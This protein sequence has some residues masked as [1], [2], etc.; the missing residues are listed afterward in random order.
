MYETQRFD[1]I[2][3]RM[4]DRVPSTMAKDEGSFVYTALAPVAIEHEMVYKDMDLALGNAFADTCDREHLIRMASVVGMKPHEATAAVWSATLSP[5]EMQLKSGARFNCGD[6]NLYVSGKDED[7]NWLLTSETKGTIA[8]KL[9]SEL[10]PIDYI[11]G[12]EDLELVGLV[13]AGTDDEDTESFRDRYLTYMQTPA[14]S[15]NEA[16]YYNWAMAVGGVGGAKV[17]PLADGPGTVSIT[18]VDDNMRAATDALVEDVAEYIEDRRP[19]GATVTIKS[20]A[21]LSITVSATITLDKGASL[22]SVINEFTQS[23]TAYLQSGAFKL[24]YVGIAY[25]GNLLIDTDGVEDYSNLKIN[26]G[27]TNVTMASDEVAVPG[28]ITLEVKS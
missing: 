3:E 21:E 26:G 28:K 1:T 9:T 19:V 8:N 5:A 27:T 24:S 16:D 12:F 4:L 2:M 22:E 20:G 18:V 23:F 7:G 10:I 11:G 15:G 17:Y 25:V 6:I 14:A 13:E